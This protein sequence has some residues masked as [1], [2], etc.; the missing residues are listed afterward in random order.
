V[1]DS[2]WSG[3]ILLDDSGGLFVGAGGE[4]PVHAHH[5]YKLVI[6]LDGRVRVAS[7]ARGPLAG[8][9]LVVHPN[10]QHSVH[11]RDARVALIFV[12]PQSGLGRCLHAQEQ[13]CAGGWATAELDALLEPL[14]TARPG[15]LPG[16]AT[17]LAGV[18]RRTPPRPLDP[19]IVRALERLDLDPSTSERVPALATSLGLSSS[20]LT[21]LFAEGLGISLVRYRLWRHLRRA[22]DQLAGGVN[23][24]T[25]AHATGFA[26]AAHLCRTFVRMMGVTPGVFSRMSVQAPAPL[27]AAQQIRSMQ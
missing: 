4:T 12:E 5:S 3:R 1:S 7:A 17:V 10:E 26:D 27:P 9:V 13:R 19:R 25:A 21:H 2:S 14:V 23:V 15:T 16:T 11:A 6:P 18:A 22:M 8:R 24:T 20:R